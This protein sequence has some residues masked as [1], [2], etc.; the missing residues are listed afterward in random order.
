[1]RIRIERAIATLALMAAAA[2]ADTIVGATFSSSGD[3]YWNN[4]SQ[5]MI[6]SSMCGN[7]GCLL[8]GKYNTSDTVDTS[9]LNWSTTG[10]GVPSDLTFSGTST[11]YSMSVLLNATANSLVF[12]WYDTTTGNKTVLFD[13]NNASATPSTLNIGAGNYG[14]YVTVDYHNGITDTYYSQTSLN[15]TNGVTAAQAAAQHFVVFEKNG[16]LYV[17]LEDALFW[18]GLNPVEGRGDYQDLVVQLGNPIATP[19]PATFALLGGALVV[20]GVLSRRRG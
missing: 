15:T 16:S 20:L 6:S 7:I 12:G 4:P 14:Y 3:A 9:M 19:E 1:M 13:S 2:S 18:N 5:D 8:T 10:G 11:S 17:G